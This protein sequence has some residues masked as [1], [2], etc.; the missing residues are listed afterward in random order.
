MIDLIL[1]HPF[2]LVFK[3]RHLIVIEYYLLHVHEYA[4]KTRILTQVVHTLFH[5]KLVNQFLGVFGGPLVLR[6][7][8]NVNFLFHIAIFKNIFSRENNKLH[9]VLKVTFDV[10]D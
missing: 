10:L 4:K 5:K 8:G 6:Y 9:K 3:M 7:T 1:I 2:I